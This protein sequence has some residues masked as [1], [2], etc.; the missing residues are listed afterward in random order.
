MRIFS[1][2]QQSILFS[3]NRLK[4]KKGEEKGDGPNRID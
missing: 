1:D 4:M 2:D 3:I